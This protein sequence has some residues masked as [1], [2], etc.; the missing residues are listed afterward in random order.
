MV[1]PR[2]L[3]SP[4]GQRHVEGGRGLIG[5][6]KRLLNGLEDGAT[7]D[8]VTKPSLGITMSTAVSALQRDYNCSAIG[9]SNARVT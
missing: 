2:S 8:A 4:L 6:P 9:A 5:V 1:L 3:L 7:G